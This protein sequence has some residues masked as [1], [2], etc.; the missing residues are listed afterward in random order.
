MIY[1]IFLIKARA[2]ISM[3]PY[4]QTQL[5]GL[6]EKHLLLQFATHSLKEKNVFLMIVAKSADGS[7]SD[8]N[9]A[10]SKKHKLLR[11][12][13]KAENRKN[14][15]FYIGLYLHLCV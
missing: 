11:F 12:H 3:E 8:L 1:L 14:Q 13:F 5:L 7:W 9:A 6:P 10:F 2:Y 15:N 4:Q